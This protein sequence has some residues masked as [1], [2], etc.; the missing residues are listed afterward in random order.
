MSSRHAALDDL[1]DAISQEVPLDAD[2]DYT[3][4]VP[5]FLSRH[6]QQAEALKLGLI[7]L[8][9]ADDVAFF[10][11]KAKPGA[12]T[13]D[14][15]EHLALAI[16]LVAALK[17]ERSIP[18]LVDALPTGGITSEGA[19]QFGMRA[20]N[21]V[22][23]KL[24]SPDLLMRSSAVG[25]AITILR[26]QPGTETRAQVLNLIRAALKDKEFLMRS[27]AL[28]QIDILSADPRYT[29]ALQE[30][31]PALQEMAQNDPF[32]MP[33]DTSNYPLRRRAKASLA[34]LK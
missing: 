2:P 23:A 30:F 19:L 34:K 17:D 4:V 32:L 8:L 16:E 7:A 28:S 18:A 29:A 26:E 27:A 9:Q 21:A 25:A 22:L 24:H 15:S 5:K 6:P 20:L 3:R 12:Y 10:D 11:P 1:L 13:E 14:D 31:V 33:G